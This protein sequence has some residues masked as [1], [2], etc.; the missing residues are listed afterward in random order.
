MY[1]IDFDDTLFNTQQFKQSRLEA[2]LSMGV[3]EQEYW[4]TYE[5]ARNDATG[6][7]T[8]SD[9][10]HADMLARVGY[11][12]ARILHALQET[13]SPES[14]PTFLN[15]N[16]IQFVEQLK[17]HGHAMIL[18]SLGEPAFQELKTV[19]SGVHEYF[20]RTF[21]VDRSKHEVLREL[22]EHTHPREAWFINDKIAETKELADAFPEM[23]VV[24]RQ[25]P[26]FENIDY[27]DSGFVHFEH[28]EEIYEYINKQ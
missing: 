7:F 26:K 12:K 13:S 15:D 10:R 14:L 16:A 2:L 8:Y 19:E 9:E 27:I 25:S 22:F 1:I 4:T 24:L 6:L 28:L 11:D 17:A 20:D 21:M 23:N 5:Q 3:S 18:L